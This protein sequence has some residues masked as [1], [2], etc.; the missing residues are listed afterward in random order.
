MSAP[1]AVQDDRA[2]GHMK[3]LT[4]VLSGAGRL[5]GAGAPLDPQPWEWAGPHVLIEHA[6]EARADALA[7]ALRRAGYSVACCPGPAAGGRCP[8]AD[9]GCAAAAGADLVVSGLGFETTAARDA[10]GALRTRLPRLPVVLEVGAGDA[11]RWPEL[12]DGCTVV[13][14]PAAPEQ[15]VAQVRATLRA[16][17]SDAA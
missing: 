3:V 2:D 13:A 17:E 14:P 10:L 15:V 11:E 6:D 9:D 1:P 5:D 4:N 7:A 12:V 16:Q 8:L